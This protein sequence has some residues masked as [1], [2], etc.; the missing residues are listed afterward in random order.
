[1]V[2]RTVVLELLGSIEHHAH[3]VITAIQ[4]VY[5]GLAPS[6]VVDN[7]FDACLLE[8]VGITELFLQNVMEEERKL[9]KNLQ[10]QLDQPLVQ[11]GL[12]V[13]RGGGGRRATC[14]RVRAS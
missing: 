10:P 2:T 8:L 7:T 11:G 9:C 14:S 3:G 12:G 4:L 6:L 13:G 1:M 5:E